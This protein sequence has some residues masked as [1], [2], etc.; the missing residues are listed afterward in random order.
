M[1]GHE[2]DERWAA[3][4]A[5]AVDRLHPSGSHLHERIQYATELSEAKGLANIEVS[6]LQGKFLMAQCQMID[7]RHVL[8]LGTLGGISS[9]YCAISPVAEPPLRSLNYKAYGWRVQVPM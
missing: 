3:V 2:K 7:A 5:Y 8:E 6:P 9:T 4:D 1:Q